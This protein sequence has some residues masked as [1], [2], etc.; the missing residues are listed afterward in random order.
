MAKDL[1][2]IVNMKMPYGKFK[3]VKLIYLPEPYLVWLKN[4]NNGF[5]KSTLGDYLSIILEIKINGLEDL[6]KPLISIE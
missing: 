1:V 4:Q 3:G 6:V 5:S 2:K